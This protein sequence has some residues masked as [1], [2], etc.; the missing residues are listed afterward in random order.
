MSITLSTSA[1][2]DAVNALADMVDVGGAGTIEFYTASFATL[3]AELSF[4]NPA[5]GAGTSGTA[6]AN[7][8][9]T[10]TSANDSG[11]LSVFQIINGE[12][13]PVLSGDVSASGGDI[14]FDSTAVI[15]GDTIR[16]DSL[17]LTVPAS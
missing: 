7:A 2:D 8:I 6:T 1:R 16:V 11:T 3:L 15:I 13:S 9:T 4:S 17:T 10:D 12:G 5:F 14:N